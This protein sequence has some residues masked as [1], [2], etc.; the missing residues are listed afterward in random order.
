VAD[1][2]LL[3]ITAIACVA[4]AAIFVRLRLR[5][6]EATTAVEETLS[7]VEFA[8]CAAVR[9]RPGEAPTCE[10]ADAGPLRIFVPR[11]EEALVEIDGAAVLP[12]S[13]PVQ[14]GRL[15]RVD[16]PSAVRKIVVRVRGERGARWEL[17]IVTP[18]V[19]AWLTAARSDRQK[20]ALDAAAEKV[21]PH[22][23]AADD[24]ARGLAHG[25]LA[26][27]ALARGSVDDAVAGLQ[28]SIEILGRTDRVSDRVEDA[29]ALAFALS[30]RSRRYDEAS[31][32]LQRTTTDAA[33]YPEGAA[34]IPYYRALLDLELGD[35][36][37]ALV[38]LRQAS[39][40]AARLDLDRALRNTRGVL[41]SVLQMNGHVERELGV[42]RELVAETSRGDGPACERAEHLLNLGLSLERRER[43]GTPSAAGAS[44]LRDVVER[45]SSLFPSCPDPHE[46]SVALY[47]RASVALT[48]GDLVSAEKAIAE[49]R[50]VVGSPRIN[51]LFI[52]TEFEARLARATGDASRARAL[53][54]AAEA[55]ASSGHQADMRWRAWFGLGE[56]EDEQRAP[57]RAL[58]AYLRA[59]EV[60]DE[61]A[62]AL[63]LEAGRGVYLR[64]A[65]R[66]ARAAIE[67]LVR[68]GRAAE[69]FALARRARARVLDATARSTGIERIPPA[70]RAQ[71]T[72]AIAR[73]R[74]AR[75]A[76]EVH[77]AAD[78]SR[79]TAALAEARRTRAHDEKIMRSALDEALAGLPLPAAAAPR[80]PAP[81]ELWLA[82]HPTRRGWAAFAADAHRTRASII[83]RSPDAAVQA[84]AVAVEAISSLRPEISAAKRLVVV[85]YGALRVVDFARI[86]LDDQPLIAHL[87][88]AYAADVPRMRSAR[89]PT[90]T[91]GLVVDPTGDLPAAHREASAVEQA[92]RGRGRS[93]ITRLSGDRAT[94]EAVLALL[95]AS[96]T[97][98]YAGHGVFAER[99]G[100]RAAFRSA[101][102]R[103]SGPSTSS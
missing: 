33:S 1:R 17:A 79:S 25:L 39:D 15:Y 60:L 7:G 9:A 72:A 84:D 76:L 53:F 98:H 86:V 49:A 94:G 63:P 10:R 99:K 50:T 51:D 73:Y 20:G 16:L 44:E 54:A 100:S 97:F 91:V 95:A 34:R 90:E 59:E 67:I 46:R 26:R 11:A 42:L 29:L 75:A 77:A 41:A 87:P 65:E 58:A 101:A 38:E 37:A 27:L 70:M 5:G 82:F 47:L 4:A 52:W 45:V 23:E 22:L 68:E 62:Q 48:G 78:W 6:P 36:R 30:Q 57:V 32:V 3:G 80:P 64:H 103:R 18:S 14:H 102:A 31:K 92:L 85:P 28:R 2:R 69:A 81:G 12:P 13:R 43:D 21:R 24:E 56:L 83:E 19:P 96:D 93:S 89:A 88:I 71:V 40:A 55:L 8:G 74:A 35:V 66:S 61:F